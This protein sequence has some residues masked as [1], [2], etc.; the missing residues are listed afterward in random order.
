MQHYFARFGTLPTIPLISKL[1]Y[2]QEYDD[3]LI[4]LYQAINLC[5]KND[6]DNPDLPLYLIK[7]G[8]IHIIKGLYE[9]AKF[10]CQTAGQMAQMS[11]N[12]E[13]KTEAGLCIETLQKAMKDSINEKQ[14]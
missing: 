8:Y 11:R 14:N 1:I 4:Y 12:E 2:F 3:S 10:W 5:K 9:D 6:P 7:V 13:A